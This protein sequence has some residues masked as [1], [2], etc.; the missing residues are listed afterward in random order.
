MPI[1]FTKSGL[2]GYILIISGPKMW[3]FGIGLQIPRTKNAGF[4]VQR[5]KEAELKLFSNKN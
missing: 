2:S 1:R 3:S 5:V 4:R